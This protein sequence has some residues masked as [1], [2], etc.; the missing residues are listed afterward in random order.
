MGDII[1]TITRSPW[2]HAALYI[3]RLHDVS[4]DMCRTTLARHARF[5]PET[6]LVI[7]SKFGEGTIVSSS[8]NYGD[9]HLRICRPE[10]L[11]ADDSES[12][13]E[14]VARYLGVAYDTRQMLGLA[15]F[16]FPW[17]VLPRRTTLSSQSQSLYA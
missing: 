12:V 6:Q 1:Q 4:S 9:D 2:T 10:G 13:I 3:G 5:S 7:E 8:D 11:S 15:C 16:F 17:K 14:H